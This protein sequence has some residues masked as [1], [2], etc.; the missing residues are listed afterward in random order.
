MLAL[1]Y[2]SIF[3]GALVLIAGLSGSTIVS[4]AKG[5]P[6]RAKALSPASGVE[7]GTLAPATAL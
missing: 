6:D 1:G 3:A 2:L 4:V 7:G 5:A